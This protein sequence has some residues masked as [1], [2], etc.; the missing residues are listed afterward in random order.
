MLLILQMAFNEPHKNGGKP[1][2]LTPEDK[3]RIALKY[4]RQYPAMDSLAAEYGVRKGSIC[5]PVQWAE[6]TFAQDGAFAPPGKKK[7]KRKPASIR[8]I[9][10]DVTES[11][12]NRLKEGQKAYY[13]GKKT[14]RLEDAGHY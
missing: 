7:L 13:S 12:V 8:Y 4:L 14:A 10:V 2:K 5:L 11:P 6:D 9:V 3:L 1:P